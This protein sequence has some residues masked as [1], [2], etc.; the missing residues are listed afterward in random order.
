MLGNAERDEVERPFI[1]QLKAM[2]WTHVRGPDLVRNSREDVLLTDRLSA[3]V[4][5][6]NR[7][8][9]GSPWLDDDRVARI[10]QTLSTAPPGGR[11]IEANLHAT[12]LLLG[13]VAVPGDRDHHHGRWG[14]VHVID[15]ERPEHNEFLV[16]D[17]LNQSAKA[18]CATNCERLP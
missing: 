2:G 1:E 7:L 9:D 15:W 8:P 17:P 3:A 18:R 14:T 10:V 12:G 16:G 4:R 13:G 11:L 6:I 5:R